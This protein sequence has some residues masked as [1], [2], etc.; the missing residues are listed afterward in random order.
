MTD[1]PEKLE[2]A[3]AVEPRCRIDGLLDGVH[4][5]L[6][7]VQVNRARLAATMGW[8]DSGRAVEVITATMALLRDGKAVKLT[9]RYGYAIF[10]P[11]ESDEDGCKIPRSYDRGIHDCRGEMIEWV[12]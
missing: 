11:L 9:S 4:G 3:G 10:S 8:S 12:S 6:T 2:G 5:P 1:L 7:E